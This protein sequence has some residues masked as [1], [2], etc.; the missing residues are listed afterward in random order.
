MKRLVAQVTT[1]LSVSTLLVFGAAPSV[2]LSSNASHHA[3]RTWIQ[4]LMSKMTVQQK[5][6]Q[7]LM[8]SFSGTTLSSQ[9]KAMIQQIQPGGVTL[10][11]D[12]FSSPQQLTALDRAIQN[13]S[14]IPLFIS[15][16]QEGGEVIRITSGVKQ[17]PSEYAYGQQDDPA[18]VKSDAAKEAKQLK[19]LGLNMNLAPVLDVAVQNSIIGEYDRSYGNDSSLVTSLGLAS[20]AGYQSQGMATVAKHVVGLGTTMTDPE[21]T[22]PYL[23]LS[24]AK[25]ADQLAPFKAATKAGVDAIMVTHVILKGVSVSPASISHAVVTGI[26]RKQFGYNGVIMTDSLTMGALSHYK[27]STACRMAVGAGE[28]ILLVAA[29]GATETGVYSQCLN[30]VLDK[31]KAG[32][33]S[34]NRINQSV[35]RILTL[36]HKLGLPLP[37]A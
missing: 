28:D 9:A 7:M 8:V 22:L 26:L 5:I 12:N 15:V 18:Q 16:D 3:Q 24:A 19:K 6:G 31:Y 23:H 2:V 20:I 33:L 30:G 17:L 1:I 11:G 34:I 27:L 36:K 32:K 10:F 25:L 4:S 29:G 13:S 37:S 35:T 21:S 14:H